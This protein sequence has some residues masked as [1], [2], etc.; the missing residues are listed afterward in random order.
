MSA[1]NTQAALPP[2]TSTFKHT[3]LE[4]VD[5]SKFDVRVHQAAK[6]PE[7]LQ[8]HAYAQGNKIHLGPGQDKHLAHESWHVVQ[9]KQGRA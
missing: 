1:L 6:K 3:G 7:A 8:A 2:R 9:Q 4:I 5:P